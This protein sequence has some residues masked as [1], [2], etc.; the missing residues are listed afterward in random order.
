MR[1]RLC[2]IAFAAVVGAGA[3]AGCVQMPRHSNT[4]VFGTNTTLG[5]KVG[6]DA[7]NTP[8]ITVGYSRQEAVVMPLVANTG[9]DGNT[10]KPCPSPVPPSTGSPLLDASCILVG[11]SGANILDSYSVMASFGAK[12]G[13]TG[14]AAEVGA[15]GQIA[16]YFATGLA[17]RELAIRAGAAAVATGEAAITANAGKIERF[18]AM[19]ISRKSVATNIR[20]AQDLALF[21][22]KLDDAV[23]SVSDFQDA[24]SGT[25]DKEACATIIE[26]GGPPVGLSVKDWAVAASTTP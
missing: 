18:T 11:K 3:L 7:T 25:A 12:F 13:A 20:A 2:R 14:K 6:T 26:R 19:G 23:R 16:Q 9:D 15:T 17:A 24:C 21:L 10:Q 1:G 8:G 22:K 5:I 4:L